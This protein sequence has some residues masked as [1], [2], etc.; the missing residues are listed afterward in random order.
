[1][2]S[3]QG[4]H[5]VNV[6][7]NTGA[8]LVFAGLNLALTAPSVYLWLGLPLLMREQGWSAW[9]LGLFQLAG[10]PAVFKFALGALVDRCPGAGTRA[11]GYRRWAV[12][13]ICA[14][15]AVLLLLGLRVGL[16]RPLPLFA[17]AALAAVL[18][19]WADIPVNALAIRW[20]PAHQHAMA[21]GLR[22]LALSLGA[23]AG[24]GLML[25]VHA[26]W[27]WVAP[28]L[29]MALVLLL[30]MCGLWCLRA[31]AV[32]DD[33][34]ADQ[35]LAS[36]PWH[37]A[38]TGYFRQPQAMAWNVM[39]I[40]G[41]AFIGA[42][43]FYLKPMLLDLGWSVAQAATVAGLQGGVLAAIAAVA[44]GALTRRFGTTRTVPPCM[45]LNTVSLL[46]LAAAVGAADLHPF[47]VRGAAWVTAIAMGASS[48]C[49]FGLMMRFARRSVQAADYGLQ[50]SLFAM[51]RL[52]VPLGAGAIL[53]TV[54]AP[55]TLCTLAAGAALMAGWA[56]RWRRQLT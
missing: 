13:L 17:L 41:F 1:M 56:W 30:A 9:S 31:P 46:M 25:L 5:T 37:S 16:D 8:H 26:R 52:I 28:F 22:S 23:V 19:T 29:V 50:A 48:A 49:L 7:R 6:A 14:Y 45:A 53:D 2:S 21:G 27:G 20:L 32:P 36:L 24:G 43:W 15:A 4:P 47:T 34:D 51:S 39:L 10:L 55:L 42:A 11:T 12:G 3:Q 40:G 38:A 54:G 44:A 18:A 33:S 35:A